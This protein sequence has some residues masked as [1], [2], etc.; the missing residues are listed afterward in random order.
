MSVI[1][2]YP[3]RHSSRSLADTFCT[4]PQR[5]PWTPWITHLAPALAQRSGSRAPST[6]SHSPLGLVDGDQGVEDVVV[7]AADARDGQHQEVCL[8][9]VE[10]GLLVQGRVLEG[11]LPALGE[12]LLAAPDPVGAGEPVA[13]VGVAD[14]VEEDVGLA[15][16]DGAGHEVALLLPLHHLPVAVDQ[17]DGRRCRGAGTGPVPRRR[18]RD[19][20]T[21][22]VS[23]KAP[24]RRIRRRALPDLGMNLR[25]MAASFGLLCEPMFAKPVWR[26][27]APA[28]TPYRVVHP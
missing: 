6:R 15:A 2:L 20:A 7:A 8:L 27:P 16:E 22:P 4:T 14:G 1:R 23:S 26:P 3:P 12:A 17:G 18:S 19:G 13:G 10:I 9:G 11:V 5:V 21:R 28:P 24:A 25:N